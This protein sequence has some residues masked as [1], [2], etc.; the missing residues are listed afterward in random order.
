MLKSETGQQAAHTQTKLE[1]HLKRRRQ[2][3]KYLFKSGNILIF[4][5]PV[6]IVLKPHEERQINMRIQISFPKQLIPEFVTFPSLTKT[7]IESNILINEKQALEVKL[8]NKSFTNTVRVKK[9]SGIVALYFLND[10]NVKFK[11]C[12]SYI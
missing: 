9:N 3:K 1:I 11:I 5:T 7:E 2:V 6:E 4:F 12:N 10:Y 8:F